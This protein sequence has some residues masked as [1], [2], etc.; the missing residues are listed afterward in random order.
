MIASGHESNLGERVTSSGHSDL[1][2]GQGNAHADDVTGSGQ[3]T[4][5]GH[6]ESGHGETGIDPRIETGLPEIES[7]HVERGSGQKT[8]TAREA[9]AHGQRATATM[10]ALYALD[11]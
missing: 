9:T 5:T 6:T 11:L 8:A 3:M 1:P 2:G 7:A 4:A 10:T